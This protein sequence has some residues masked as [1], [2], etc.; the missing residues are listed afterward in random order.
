[1][2]TAIR[3]FA[4]LLIAIA[5]A[6]PLAAQ[7][8]DGTTFRWN[9]PVPRA[10]FIRLHNMNGDIRVERASGSQVEV[11]AT[12]RVE[13]GDPK[14]VKFDV[15]MRSDGDVVICALWGDEQECTD[16]GTRGNYRSGNWG[17][18]DNISVSMRVRV[19]DGVKAFARST[20]G[21][22]DV[23]GVTAEVDAASTNGDVNVRTSGGPV[24]ART[25]NGSVTAS[26]GQLDGSA[27]MRFT[28]TNGSVTVYA[29]P[30]ID[31]DL[32]MSTTNGVLITDYPLTVSG[33]IARNSVRGTLGQGG[34]SIVVRSTNGNV[35]LKR[36]GI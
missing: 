20:N 15:R 8:D 25:T 27:P 3:R 13:R 7:T 36:N 16:D 2:R 30:A 26:L 33:Q 9:G 29:P 14:T 11:V 23:Q 28:T 5:A 6:A 12:R 19:P 35:A 22:V 34:R 17:R 4:P 24:N 31:A 32:E 21:G 10:R 18:G 1:M